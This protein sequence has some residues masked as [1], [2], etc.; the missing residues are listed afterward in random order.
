MFET[1][2]DRCLLGGSELEEITTSGGAENGTTGGAVRVRAKAAPS[3][4]DIELQA[5]VAAVAAAAPSILRDDSGVFC[6]RA[7]LKVDKNGRFSGLGVLVTFDEMTCG[8]VRV[9][10]KVCGG[11]D[12]V[13]RVGA[14]AN[15]ALDVG[16]RFGGVK[17]SAGSASAGAGCPHP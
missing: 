4:R 15:E 13:S 17:E 2:N 10:W 12:T 3:A 11:P 9:G 1:E 6:F 7:G 16:S 14:L 5:R 8:D